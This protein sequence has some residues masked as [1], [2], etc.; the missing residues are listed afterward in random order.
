MNFNDLIYKDLNKLSEEKNHKSSW[1]N[2]FD[3]NRKKVRKKFINEYLEKFC[4]CDVK[5]S[6]IAK[7]KNVVW[8]WN[9]ENVKII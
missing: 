6:H 4:N 8:K 3:F 9:D 5:N 7:H 2:K 1:L